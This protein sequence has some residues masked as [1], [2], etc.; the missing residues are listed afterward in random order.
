MPID[1]PL[2]GRSIAITRPAG[3]AAGLARAI[4]AAGGRALLF[5]V[6]EIAPVEDETGLAAV[7]AGLDRFHLAFFVSPNAVELALAYLLPRRSWPAHLA[8]ATVG[9]GSEAALAR[10]GFD[11]VIAPTAG[12][13]S[14]AVL[15]LPEFQAAVVADREVVI[16]RGDGGRDLLGDTLKERGARVHYVACYRRRIPATDAAPLLDAALCGDLDALVLTSSEGVANLRA[17]VGPVDWPILTAVPA[18]VPHP[19]IAEAARR[20]GFATVLESGPG[21]VGVLAAL[22]A[23]LRGRPTLG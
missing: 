17:M 18:V 19:R 9:K 22:E 5:P 7:C 16:F 1:R 12:F 11:R 8:V 14:E 21:D 10:A 23:G 6:I 20:A 3:Q 4:E 13:D 2:A 15:A